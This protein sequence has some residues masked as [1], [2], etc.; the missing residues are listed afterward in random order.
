MLRKWMLAPLAVA[1]LGLAAC[2]G[3]DK[4][5]GK[6]SSDG[7]AAGATLKG[8]TIKIGAI[9]PITG[10]FAP[11]GKGNRDG[12]QAAVD[13]LN[14]EGSESGARYELDVRDD[15]G[16]LTQSV[17]IA[18]EFGNSVTALVAGT[19]GG[20][21]AAIAPVLTRT[22]IPLVGAALTGIDGQAR[23]YPWVYGVGETNVQR[24]GPQVRYAI[25]NSGGAPIAEIHTTDA[26]G[27]AYG[28]AFEDSLKGHAVVS[29]GVAPTATDMTAQLRDLQRSG[30]KALVINTFGEPF[31][32]IAQNLAQLG[33]RPKVAT[34]LGA[35]SPGIVDVLKRQA[36]EVLGTMQAGPLPKP[37]L[38]AEPGGQPSTAMGQ[39]W[40]DSMK[41]VTKR[42][43]LSGDDLVGT[44]GFDAVLA[45]DRALAKA[46]STDG[47]KLREALDATSFDGSRGR[48]AFTPDNHAGQQDEDLALAQAKYPCSE[49]ACVAAK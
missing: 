46:G 20:S 22:R 1:V 27:T 45:I 39:A 10:P 3:D 17:A 34:L 21:A 16:N 11:S 43:T 48:I 49:G 15:Q 9:Y 30:A 29:K 26:F 41:A 38:T 24:Q 44:Y 40:A 6:A 37:L 42:S 8:Q 14:S 7:A 35:L 31:I 19:T 28:K 36:P 13:H 12:A 23:K 5:S 2:G 47:T 32:K 25:E 18:R 33:W 4:G